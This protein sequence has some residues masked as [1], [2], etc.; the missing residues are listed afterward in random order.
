MRV[1]S[2]VSYLA[3][4]I[5]VFAI[6]WWLGVYVTAHGEPPALWALAQAWHG[7]AIGLAWAFTNCGWVQVFAPFYLAA[8]FIAIRYRAWRARMVAL[9]ITGLVTWGVTDVLQHHFARPRR[10]DWLIR[11]EHSFSYPSSHAS[12]STAFYL[13]AGLL[14]L[15]SDLPARFRYPA[16]AALTALSLGI[17]WSRLSLGA[18]YPTDVAG[19]VML[20]FVFVLVSSAVLRSA[21][22]SGVRA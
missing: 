1:R 18:H 22:K 12:T 13:Y 19:G 2:A 10:T 16:F 6:F 8:I 7:K 4:A 11:H 21:S 20:G 3:T 5:V 17:W 9:V 14:I 15:F